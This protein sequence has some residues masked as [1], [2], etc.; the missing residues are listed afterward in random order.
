MIDPQFY[1]S[2]GPKSLGELI[3]GMDVSLDPH[4]YDQAIEI[5]AAIAGA[6]AGQIVF[7][8][9][10]RRKL[11]L[12]GSEATA[13]LVTENLA[14]FVS[15]KHI[16]PIMSK[17]PRAHFARICQKLIGINSQS[18]PSDISEKAKIHPTA[19]I[20]SNVVIGEGVMIGPYTIIGDGVKI[21]ANSNLEP[22]V[23]L[24]FC[25]IGTDCRIKSGAVIGG[26]G[27]GV[28]K[29][30]KGLIDL[31]HLGRVMIGDR[32]SIGSQTCVDR[33]QL[34]DTLIADDVKV[35]NLVQIAHN[36]TIG[37][38]SMIAGHAGISGSCSIGKNVQMG[39]NAG[40]SDHVTI[41]DNVMIAAKAGV[42]HNIPAGEAW[43]GVPAMPMR[44]YMRMVS[45]TRK[46]AK[47][48]KRDQR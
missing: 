20:G 27:F 18:K 31:P 43:G 36:V 35:D 29:D 42:M 33:G 46:L 47:K 5:P 17:A 38:G 24:S 6:Q 2:L 9:D 30:E 23:N 25:E 11:E 28:A 13:C 44:E 22:H 4:F 19:I 26:S 34:G 48:P 32:V 10:K 41:G 45:A 16:I 40:L 1:T 12:E 8:Q 15:D 39:G 14:P 3:E 7:F 37:R 21:G